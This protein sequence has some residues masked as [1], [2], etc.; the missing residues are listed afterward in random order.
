MP[1]GSIQH[2]E[3]AFGEPATCMVNSIHW[4]NWKACTALI[5]GISDDLKQQGDDLFQ[6]VL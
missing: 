3:K 6:C 1:C 2:S 5:F 4:D